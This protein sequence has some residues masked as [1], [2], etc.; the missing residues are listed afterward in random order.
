MMHTDA[1]ICDS[2]AVLENSIETGSEENETDR[3]LANLYTSEGLTIDCTK[4]VNNKLKIIMNYSKSNI[5][6]IGSL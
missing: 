3:M 6:I 1:R 4:W 5:M 2:L